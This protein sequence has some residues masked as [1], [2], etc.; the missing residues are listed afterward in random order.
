MNTINT[1]KGSFKGCSY[2]NTNKYI[3]L[4]LVN[5]NSNLDNRNNN[6]VICNLVERKD[7]LRNTY[8][9]EYSSAIGMKNQ[10]LFYEL[11]D[12]EQII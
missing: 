11:G 4:T 5:E 1:S 10:S 7:C 9:P 12:N 8:I 2:T 3:Y 6:N